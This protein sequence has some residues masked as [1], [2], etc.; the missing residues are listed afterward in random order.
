MKK[1]WIITLSLLFLVGLTTVII[2]NN[3]DYNAEKELSNSSAVAEKPAGLQGISANHKFED[4]AHEP[5]VEN[6]ECT[7][8]QTGTLELIV[9]H[10]QWLTFESKICDIN[11]S[12]VDNHQKRLALITYKCAKCD[13]GYSPPDVAEYQ[14]VCGHTNP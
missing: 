6:L 9:V 10:T 1:I 4:C 14:T 12:N 8:C 3:N 5:D 13:Y 7:H 2:L 11:V